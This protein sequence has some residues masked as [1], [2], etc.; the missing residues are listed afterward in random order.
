MIVDY[1]RSFEVN[2]WT[3]T[4]PE[5]DTNVYLTTIEKDKTARCKMSYNIFEGGQSVCLMFIL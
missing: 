4:D 5:V 3:K 1:D 2:P